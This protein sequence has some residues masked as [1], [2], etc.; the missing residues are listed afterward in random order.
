MLRKILVMTLL[1]ALGIVPA[2]F[3]QDDAPAETE[4]Q[5]IEITGQGFGAQRRNIIIGMVW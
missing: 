5:F 1:V 2:A 4:V 3:A